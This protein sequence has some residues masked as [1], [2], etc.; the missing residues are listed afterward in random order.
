MPRVRATGEYRGS[1]VSTRDPAPN[2]AGR[3]IRVPGAHSRWL[4]ISSDCSLFRPR[5]DAHSLRSG[6]RLSRNWLGRRP[7]RIR[8][9]GSDAL[10]VLCPLDRWID[11][12]CRLAPLSWSRVARYALQFATGHVSRA[13]LDPRRIFGFIA[14]Q[15]RRI[16]SGMAYKPHR[17]EPQYPSPEVVTTPS[18]APP[19]VVEC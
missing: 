2:E 9:R 10:C 13:P 4:A 3:K 16:S 19:V 18:P 6:R 12:D 17:L 14:E 7:K 8:R 5:R 1:D 15:R 11:V